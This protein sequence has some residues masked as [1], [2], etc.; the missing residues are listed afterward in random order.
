MSSSLFEPELQPKTVAR[1]ITTN[2]VDF[3]AALAADPALLT[4]VLPFYSR[5]TLHGRAPTRPQS[6]SELFLHWS[7]CENEFLT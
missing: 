3:P 4:I 5:P 7:D 2:Q 1:T 6:G